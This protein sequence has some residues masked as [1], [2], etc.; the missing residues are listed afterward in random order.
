MY[1]AITGN[2]PEVEWRAPWL[3]SMRGER[4]TPRPRSVLDVVMI[5][6]VTLALI[7]F[8]IWFFAFA[9]SSLPGS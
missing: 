5:A 8:A 6:S 4:D 9:G 1:G 7:A 3:K 2:N